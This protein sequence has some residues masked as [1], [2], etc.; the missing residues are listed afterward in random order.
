MARPTGKEQRRT[1]QGTAG[2]ML[3]RA[4]LGKILDG[5]E[6]SGERPRKNRGG[7]LSATSQGGS[8]M[9]TSLLST[10]S[11]VKSLRAGL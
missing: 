4:Q 8:H 3:S 6:E 1:G 2:Q 9:G 5:E 11:L 10:D 7:F